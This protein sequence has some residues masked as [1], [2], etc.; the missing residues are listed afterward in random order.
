MNGRWGCFGPVT[1]ESNATRSTTTSPACSFGDDTQ[2]ACYHADMTWQLEAS[3]ISM[4]ALRS[5]KFSCLQATMRSVVMI[6]RVV[7]TMKGGDGGSEAASTLLRLGARSA[8]RSKYAR[9]S[10]YSSDPVTTHSLLHPCSLQTSLARHAGSV[11]LLPLGHH[12]SASL[13]CQSHVQKH[14]FDFRH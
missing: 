12:P 9:D 5:S 11:V 1:K 6:G 7:V 10:Q 4:K 2:R 14:A 8:S 13:D 3:V